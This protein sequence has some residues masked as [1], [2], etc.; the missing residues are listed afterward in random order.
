MAAAGL[1][2]SAVATV[3]GDR[4]GG[5]LG[6]VGQRIGRAVRCR[7]LCG[8]AVPGCV[9]SGGVG[10]RSQR[11]KNRLCSSMIRYY[12][13]R[14]GDEDG[15]LRP[16]KRGTR[17]WRHLGIGRGRGFRRQ[18]PTVGRNRRGAGGLCA[19]IRG[20]CCIRRVPGVGV[21]PC[22]RIARRCG[23]AGGRPGRGCGNGCRL[24]DDREGRTFLRDARRRWHRA[25]LGGSGRGIRL[26]PVRMAGGRGV[27]PDLSW[28]R[29]VRDARAMVCTGH[30]GP[31]AG[32]GCFR[33]MVT[34]WA[35]G[36]LRRRVWSRFRRR[37]AV[38]LCWRRQISFGGVRP[39]RIGR[40]GGQ[41]FCTQSRAART[42]AGVWRHAWH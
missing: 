31:G 9:V 5:V 1:R 11:D 3:G 33:C 42:E 15:G 16:R 25:P 39:G 21:L 30:S 28:W 36:S 13:V 32:R 26:A 4:G 6:G 41:P 38:G 8:R 24:R 23:R 37:R 34:F 14:K 7:E 22:Q 10:R 12:L 27:L 29:D 2:G 18:V 40:Q 17:L 35:V 19:D 20:C